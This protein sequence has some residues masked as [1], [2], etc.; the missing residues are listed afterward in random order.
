M[1]NPVN[2]NTI[3]APKTPAQYVYASTNLLLREFGS[4][5]HS[6]CDMEAAPLPHHPETNCSRRNRLHCQFKRK[7]EGCTTACSFL[8]HWTHLPVPA[9]NPRKIARNPST[10]RLPRSSIPPS[11]ASLKS[12]NAWQPPTRMIL[13]QSACNCLPIT[14]VFET[15]QVAIPPLRLDVDDGDY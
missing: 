6:I 5:N 3:D 2:T 12:P 14:M 13:S 11:K 8:C 4:H 7:C 9:M 1:H 10:P 15:A